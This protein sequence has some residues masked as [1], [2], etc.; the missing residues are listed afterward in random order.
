MA[1]ASDLI[2]KSGMGGPAPAGPKPIVQPPATPDVHG[3]HPKGAP[4]K[5]AK[6][7]PHA[8]GGAGGPGGRPKV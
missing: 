2:G 7:D 5:A 6:G 1:K 8:K 3:K 4:P